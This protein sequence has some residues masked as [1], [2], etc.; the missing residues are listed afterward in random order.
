MIHPDVAS[1]KISH[2]DKLNLAR[3]GVRGI[4]EIFLQEESLNLS[5]SKID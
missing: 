1:N 4:L 5:S 2:L 3:Y